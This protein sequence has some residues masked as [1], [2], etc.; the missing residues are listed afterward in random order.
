MGFRNPS[1]AWGLSTA[2]QQ[3]RLA[4]PRGRVARK[5]IKNTLSELAVNTTL[6]RSVDL[7]KD[8]KSLQR[9]MGRIDLWTKT[10][11]MRL[12]K[13]KYQVKDLHLGN[14]HPM[15][16]SRLGTEW[17]ESDPERSVGVVWQ[18]FEYEPVCAPVAKKASGILACISNSDP[19]RT[20]ARIVPLYSA[21]MKYWRLSR[22]G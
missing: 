9:D 12:N 22:E 20:R 17:L 21:L 7:L 14:N 4:P 1:A 10:S 11:C 2:V 3:G 15:E 13:V 8:M 6:G 18:L 5:E 19:S 16:P